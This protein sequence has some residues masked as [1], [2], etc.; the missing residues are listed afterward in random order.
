MKIF[1]EYKPEYEN[2][3]KIKANE[4]KERQEEQMKQVVKDLAD[5]GDDILSKHK[6][7]TISENVCASELASKIKSSRPEIS[8][9]FRS[10]ED[11][12]DE[13]NKNGWYSFFYLFNF[14]KILNT[15]LDDQ[16]DDDDEEEE[17]AEDKMELESFKNFLKREVEKTSKK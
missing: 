14:L 7:K 1:R 9:A 8:H 13:H 2:L 6:K 17:T 11:E 10:N 3:K 15:F 12:Y 16:E 4:G 5:E